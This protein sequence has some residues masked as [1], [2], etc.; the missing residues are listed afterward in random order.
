MTL[1]K[2]DPMKL[3]HYTNFE[4]TTKDELIWKI[5]RAT[6][7]AP[8]YFE[9]FYI[10]EEGPFFDGGLT[11]NNPTFTALNKILNFNE[12][13]FFLIFFSSPCI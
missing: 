1:G 3:V 12:V 8:G 6:S 10:N 5:A 7:A 2:Q 9:K 13:T 11:A 4:S